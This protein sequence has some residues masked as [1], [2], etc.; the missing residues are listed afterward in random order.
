[1]ERDCRRAAALYGNR[2][3]QLL[4]AGVREEHVPSL[5]HMAMLMQHG[6]GFDRNEALA[7]RIYEY[8]FFKLNS[9]DAANSLGIMYVKGKIGRAHV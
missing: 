3:S 9:L 6:A 1:M 5:N 4:I 7:A 8:T 2:T